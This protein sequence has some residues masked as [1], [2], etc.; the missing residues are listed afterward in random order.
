MANT[1]KKYTAEF[2]AQVA[3]AAM[4]GDKTVAELA[5]QY[6]VHSTLIVQ[7]KKRLQEDASKLFERKKRTNSL[8]SIR[9]P[10]IK[11]LGSWRWN[12]IS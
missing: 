3:M 6:E 9:M 7:W 4:R 1:R 8:R 2:K 5:Q 11:R 12:G 10:C